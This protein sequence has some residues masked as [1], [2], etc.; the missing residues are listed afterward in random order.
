[1]KSFPIIYKFEYN[2]IYNYLFRLLLRAINDATISVMTCPDPLD[3]LAQALR[4][5]L[6]NI[7]QVFNN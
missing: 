2:N 4:N 7:A 3:C 1:M 6:S 5:T